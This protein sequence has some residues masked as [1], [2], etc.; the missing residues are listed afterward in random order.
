MA[1]FSF[2]YPATVSERE[3]RIYFRRIDEPDYG[4]PVEEEIIP[5]GPWRFLPTCALYKVFSHL[6][7]GARFNASLTCRAWNDM[8]NHPNLW[9]RRAFKFY[10]YR[11]VAADMEKALAFSKR[12]GQHLQ[13]L[14]L[15]C[16]HP[17]YAVCKK[18]QKTVTDV[19]GMF[20]INNHSKLLFL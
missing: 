10:G 14:I 9:R 16:E 17:T 4:D 15:T 13:S 12:F 3:R 2:N 5:E 7:D 18:F 6:S 1:T 11:K 19:C 8:F 20:I